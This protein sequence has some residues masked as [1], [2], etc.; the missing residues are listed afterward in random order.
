MQLPNDPFILEL[1]PE[2]IDDWIEKLDSEY[3]DYRKNK[4]SESLYRFA[5]TMKGSSYQFGFADLG[6]IGVEIMT[7]VK[8]DDW[9][10]IE[11][12]IEKFRIRLIEIKDFLSQNS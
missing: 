10:G 6:D 7:Q 9:D 8:S 11:Q 1:L 5:H 2:F 3:P 12:N 4:D